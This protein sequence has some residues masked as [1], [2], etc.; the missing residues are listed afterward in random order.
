MV[1]SGLGSCSRSD[2]R[3]DMRTT[4]HPTVILLG[5]ALA[6]CSGEE[7]IAA[8]PAPPVNW[9]V[10]PAS[11]VDAGPPRATSKERAVANAYEQAL[12]APG[13]AGLGAVLDEDARMTYGAD[14][15]AL[16]RERVLAAYDRLFGAFDER[17]FIAT[18]L[19]LTE[20]SQALEW[21]MK[22][23][24][25]RAWL[26]VEA[27]HKPV[28]VRGITMM[29]TK[30]DGSVTDTHVYFDEALLKAQLGV[31]PKELQALPV[32]AVPPHQ[33]VDLEQTGAPD[34]TARVQVV[35]ASLDALEEGREDAYLA[36]MTDDVELIT[37]QGQT[38]KGKDK[39]STYFRTMRKSLG[40]L[41][42]TIEAA[43]G[44][45]DQVVI[46]YSIS[47]EQRGPVG[48][49][50]LIRDRGIRLLVV[51]VVGFREGRIARITRY[52]DQG[53][54]AADGN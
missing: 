4:L 54:L 39:A 41:D 20:N 22:G 29:W 23:V 33:R 17:D 50:P 49:V 38:L 35:R 16:G 28:V 37:Q 6:A 31:G 11:T 34:E 43:W 12:E 51:D 18:R 7:K 10:R 48:L 52:D 25:A 24:Q 21:T 40:Q 32:P 36:T 15:K 42:T 1:A 2:G 44:V 47:G 13:F 3:S 46:E 45:G 9:A 19:W 14:K 27:T 5:T 53:A 30:D 26:G 8:P